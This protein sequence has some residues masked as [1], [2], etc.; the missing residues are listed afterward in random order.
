MLG[1][2]ESSLGGTQESGSCEFMAGGWSLGNEW[3]CRR[4]WGGKRIGLSGTD[5]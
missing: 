4:V 1:A 3:D 2:E 5:I